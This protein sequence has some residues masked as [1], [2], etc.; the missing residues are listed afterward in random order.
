MCDSWIPGKK[1]EDLPDGRKLIAVRGDVPDDG[2]TFLVR[3]RRPRSLKHHRL[4]WGMLRGVVEASDGWKTPE[5]LHRWIKY[6]LGLYKMVEVRDGRVI[7]EWDSTD[8][9][10]MDQIKFEKFFMLAVAEICLKTGID[11]IEFVKEEL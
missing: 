3:I 1:V 9:F 11:P 4:Y 6:Q 7:V 5:A 8:F 2:K 10:S